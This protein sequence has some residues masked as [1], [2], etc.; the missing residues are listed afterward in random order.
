MNRLIVSLFVMALAMTASPGRA[1]P[2]KPNGADKLGWKL[3]LQ[4]WTM[5]F[6][7]EKGWF[8]RLWSD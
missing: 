4:S 2:P 6:V 5:N 8:N 3:T 1:D 7:E